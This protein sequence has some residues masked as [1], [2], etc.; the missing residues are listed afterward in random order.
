MRD[1]QVIT[2]GTGN[3]ME[4]AVNIICLLLIVVALGPSTY[5]GLGSCPLGLVPVGNPDNEG[6]WSGESYGGYGPDRICGAVDYN[7]NIGKYEV[8]AEQYCAFLNAVAG[9]D[10]YGLYNGDMWASDRGCKI[11]RYDGTGTSA[12]PYQYRVDTDWAKRPANFVSWGD[13]ARFCNWLHNGQP[14]GTQDLAT[15]EDG[16]YYLDG[17][18][19]DADLQ[20]VSRKTGWKWAIPTEDE[21][22]KAAYYDPAT[23]SYFDYP[24]SSDSMPGRDMT[25]ATNPGNNANYLGSPF[26][27]DSPHFTTV[28]GEFELSDS[29]YGTF[30]QGGNIYEW[31]ETILSDE[32]RVLRGG[33]FVEDDDNMHAASRSGDDS[34]TDE[35]YNIG[36]RVVEVPEPTAVSLLVLGGLALVRRRKLRVCK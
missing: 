31:N 4:K 18:V 34:P 11:E 33:S 14:D 2:K 7:Y 10:S 30:D 16:A 29:P 8:T 27:I 9:V 21:W 22:Y 19:S 24:T 5:A 35:Y 17:A 20:A 28:G 32:Y 6:E 15:T 12:N 26:P 23:S 25:E 3:I 13:A 1:L 36:F